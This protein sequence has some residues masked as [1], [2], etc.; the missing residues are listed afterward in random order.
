MALKMDPFPKIP[1]TW[2]RPMRVER[3][4][5][6]PRWYSLG[7][8]RRCKA[9]RAVAELG[10]RDHSRGPAEGEINCPQVS[11]GLGLQRKG[12]EFVHSLFEEEG[13]T[14]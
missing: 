12:D 13:E 8:E 7:K 6:R 14:T 2:F 1:K 11:R 10:G 3:K 9:Q 5:E 4:G